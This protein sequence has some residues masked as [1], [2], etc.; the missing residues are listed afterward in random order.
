MI[1]AL[2]EIDARENIVITRTV[3]NQKIG[4]SGA[5]D[6]DIQED[7]L[8]YQQ[9]PIYKQILND[10]DLAMDILDC[11]ASDS[12]MIP[13]TEALGRI[14]SEIKYACPPGFPVLLYGERINESHIK[15]FT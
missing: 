5:L 3:H 6:D 1:K 8:K 11:F 14:S 15:F 9:N 12:E 10:R 4:P 2:R 7:S 13:V